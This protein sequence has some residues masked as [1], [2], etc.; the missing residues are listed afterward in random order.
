MV[1]INVNLT[2]SSTGTHNVTLQ[3]T[4]HHLLV[5]MM[6]RISFALGQT[7]CFHETRSYLALNYGDDMLLLITQLSA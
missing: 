7:G 6:P 3:P 2:L 1:R 4:V 5:L